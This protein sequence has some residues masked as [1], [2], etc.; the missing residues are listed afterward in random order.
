MTRRNVAG[1]LAAIALLLAGV[2]GWYAF[3]YWNEK[4][5]PS[6]FDGQR[7]LADVVTQVGFG[8]RIPGTEGHARFQEWLSSELKANGWTVEIQYSQQNGHPVENILAKRGSS[9]PE[10]LLGAHYDSRIYA[11]NDP[12]PAL[13][14]QPVPAANDGASGVAVL[15]ELARS[16]PVDTPAVWLAFFDAEDN[17]RIGD[18]DWILGSRAFVAQNPVSP[19]AVVIVD[20]VGDAD[21][22]LH[23]EMNSDPV[24]RAEI[25]QVA[26]NQGYG[27]FFIPKVKYSM[28]DD[29]TPFL[30]AG[31]D[32]VDIID[33]DYPYFHTTQDT[34]DKISAE[35]LNAV[36][37]T[38]RAWI[39]GWNQQPK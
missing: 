4:S 19:R 36:G 10:I 15:V 30:E 2:L 31:L 16:L 25:W 21:L 9:A 27:R 24:L 23:Y 34:P 14:Q 17:G 8:P 38:L 13:R 32:A 18:W 28:L 6:E 7:A 26:E 5:I 12:N 11:D 29:H 35:S 22:N 37:A 1:Y 39:M 3:S 20:M 33:F